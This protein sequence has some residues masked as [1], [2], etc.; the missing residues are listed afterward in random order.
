MKDVF[1]KK[2]DESIMDGVISK[3]LVE[4]EVLKDPKIEGGFMAAFDDMAPKLYRF[5][6]LR[7][8]SRALAE[9]L[10]SETFLKTWQ[11]LSRGQKVNSY[12]VFLYR[13]M[14]NLIVDHWRSKSSHE[15]LINEEMADSLVDHRN[16][17]EEIADDIEFKRILGGLG[18]LPKDQQNILYWRFVDE[19]SIKE[20]AELSGKKT[21]AIY[22]SIYRSI[23]KLK[24]IFKDYV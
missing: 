8:G 7:V 18:K 20:I 4:N 10:V 1:N 13:V 19:L 24:R 14:N 9:D 6:V 11:Y 16:L 22:V 21:N 17:P 3:S 23:Q 2:G 12:P 15:V 5:C